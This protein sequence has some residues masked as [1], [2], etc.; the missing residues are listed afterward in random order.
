VAP[1]FARRRERAAQESATQAEVERLIGLPRA[2]L[3]VEV[4]AGFGPDGPHPWPPARRA[5]N[6]IELTEW[7]LRGHAR[8]GRHVRALADPVRDALRLLEAA[9]LIEWR[10]S[11]MVGAR[12]RLS[13]TAL[14][15][16]AL[17]QGTVRD[18]L[19]EDEEDQV[20]PP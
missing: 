20:T 3:A 17:A 8:A 2:E 5:P 16:V 11:E 7:L 6:L 9:G 4:M 10:G 15:E 14:G 12:A 19:E 13:A 1:L 18:H